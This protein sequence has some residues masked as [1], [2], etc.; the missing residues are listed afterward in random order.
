MK[1]AGLEPIGIP[2]ICRN[3]KQLSSRKLMASFKE[4]LSNAVSLFCTK[5]CSSNK[6]FFV[7]F[8]TL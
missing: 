7:T 6:L 8:E 4:S 5:F 2:M 3:D 1:G